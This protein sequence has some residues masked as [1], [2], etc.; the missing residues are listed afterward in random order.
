VRPAYSVLG[1]DRW[2]RTGLPGLPDWR[3]M[4]SQAMAQPAFAAAIQQSTNAE[5]SQ[6]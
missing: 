5:K 1:H 4:L 6:P 3:G 2:S